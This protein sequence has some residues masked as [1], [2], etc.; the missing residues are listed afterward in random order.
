ML[1]KGREDG[2]QVHHLHLG[3]VSHPFHTT[4]T[5]ITTITILNETATLLSKFREA[6][7][8]KAWKAAWAIIGTVSVQVQV[9]E[10][11]GEGQRVLEL[12]VGRGGHQRRP[13]LPHVLIITAHNVLFN[14]NCLQ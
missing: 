9:A 3:Q 6:I 11:A 14:E 12:G 7:D 8:S 2:R 13:F 10:R 5:I 1:L 4:T